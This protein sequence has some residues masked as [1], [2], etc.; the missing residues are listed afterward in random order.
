MAIRVPDEGRRLNRP[1]LGGPIAATDLPKIRPA[2]TMG[3]LPGRPD[4]RRRAA[5]NRPIV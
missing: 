5:P 1:R 3:Q 2:R 4:R